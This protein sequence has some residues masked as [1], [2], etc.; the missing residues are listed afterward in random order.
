MANLPVRDLKQYPE[1]MDYLEKHP[2]YISVTTSP[3]RIGYLH[4]VIETL[5]LTFVK[6]VLVNLPLVYER[7]KEKYDEQLVSAITHIPK[8]KVLRGENDLGPITKL[9]PGI[10]YALHQDP[11]SLVITIDDDIGYNKA[12]INEIIYQIVV[13]KGATVSGSGNNMDYWSIRA[14]FPGLVIDEHLSPPHGCWSPL[15]I[16]FKKALYLSQTAKNMIAH[17]PDALT[18]KISGCLNID[19]DS[20]TEAF[21]GKTLK[22]LSSVDNQKKNP[23]KEPD[24]TENIDVVEGFAMI[25]Y[26]AKNVDVELMELMVNKELMKELF[27]QSVAKACFTSDDLVISF[28]LALTG[29]ERKKIKNGYIDLQINRDQALREFSY[30]L[31]ADAL[32]KGAG[33]D[34]EGF[35]INEKKYKECYSALI[36]LTYDHHLHR[37]KTRTEILKD[38]SSSIK[39]VNSSLL[40]RPGD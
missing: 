30:G 20:Q 32:H 36:Q 4:H 7:T 23:E 16:F 39:K 27:N 28:I 38:L 34:Q 31:G 15:S 29:I 8:V 35:N 40:L 11:D 14:P 21:I 25:G 19:P 3:N 6:N 13:N 12:L 10:K 2:V 22:C 24:R 9:I 26:T 37:F 18:N 5:D 17:S 33:I 1:I